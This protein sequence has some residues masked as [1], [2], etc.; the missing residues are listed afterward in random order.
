MNRQPLPDFDQL[1][2][3][4]SGAARQISLISNLPAIN[5]D[6]RIA[7]Q[8]EQ[9]AMQMQNMQTRLLERLDQ[10]SKQFTRL[11]NTVSELKK[12]IAELKKDV[13]ELKQDVASL[14]RETISIDMRLDVRSV[15]ILF[16]I[17]H[18]FL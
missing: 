15:S 10:H 18:F 1:S 3:C 8:F 9:F 7:A 6:Q 17:F 4:L 13:A 11:K 2:Q 16:S 14:K 5:L 12:D